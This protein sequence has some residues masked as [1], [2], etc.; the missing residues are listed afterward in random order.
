MAG[1]FQGMSNSGATV[2]SGADVS[3]WIS[4]VFLVVFF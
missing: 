4:L 1:V 3:H 2:Y